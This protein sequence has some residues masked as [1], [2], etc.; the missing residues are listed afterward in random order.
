MAQHRELVG[1]QVWAQRVRAQFKCTYNCGQVCS[2]RSPAL[3]SV[4]KV[5]RKV[6][7]RCGEHGE[8]SDGSQG[9]QRYDGLFC[10]M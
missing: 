10:V 4:D 5:C 2:I 9:P 3:C 8:A 1:G 6:Q 7:V